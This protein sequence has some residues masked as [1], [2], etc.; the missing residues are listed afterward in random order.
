MKQK[1][2]TLLML[3]LL[4]SP[5]SRGENQPV[6]MPD[7][8]Y[9]SPEALAFQRYGEYEVGEYTGNAQISVPLYTLKYKDI[10]IP[11]SLT[12]QGGGIRVDE[13][14][15]WVGL[16]WNLVVGGCIN[17]IPAG[18][19]DNAYARHAP[20]GDYY[21]FLNQNPAPYF[22]TPENAHSSPNLQQDLR[23]GLGERDFYSVTVLGKTFLFFMNPYTDEPVILG[24]NDQQFKIETFNL[25]WLVTD[26]DGTVFYFE[27]LET[28]RYGEGK[29]Y[30]SAWYLTKIVSSKGAVMIFNYTPAKNIYFL[31]KVCQM[32]DYV[33]EA[34][35]VFGDYSGSYPTSGFRS[36]AVQDTY[37][38]EKGY[39]SSIVTDDC[40]VTFSVGSREDISGSACRLNEINV[41]SVLTHQT[42][43]H[44]SFNYSYFSGENVGGDY[45]WNPLATYTVSD[46]K[47]KR[48]KLI[49]VEDGVTESERLKYGFEYNETKKLPYKTSCAT[50]FW[51]FYNGKEN[52]SPINNFSGT[53]NTFIPTPSSF[54]LGTDQYT[55]LPDG[56]KA[57]AVANRFSDSQYITAGSLRRIIYPTKGYTDFIF[58]PH[59]FLS[60]LS[61]PDAGMEEDNL[62]FIVTDIN[63]TGT[64]GGPEISKL[65]TLPYACEGV[66]EV[67]FNGKQGIPLRQFSAYGAC[68]TLQDV[69]PPSRVSYKVVPLLQTGSLDTETNCTILLPVSLPAGK[70]VMISNLPSQFGDNPGMSVSG[71]LMLR[72]KEAMDHS[73]G[74]GLRIKAIENY[75]NNGILLK[76]TEYEYTKQD[77]TTSGLLLYP[78]DPTEWL[79]IYDGP[80]DKV[81]VTRFKALRL[82]S[83]CGGVPTFTHSVSKGTVGYSRIVKKTSCDQTKSGIMIS[84]YENSAAFNAVSRLYLFT[85]VSNGNL[86]S[87]IWMTSMGD[88]IR[89]T[90]NTYSSKKRCDY[91]C[92]ATIGKDYFPS[93]IRPLIP[94]GIE[95]WMWN[96]PHYF[97]QAYSYFSEWQVLTRSITIDYVDGKPGVKIMHDYEYNSVNHLLTRDRVSSSL[98][99]KK[100]TTEYSYPLSFSDE[101]VYSEMTNKHIWSPIVEQSLYVSEGMMDK[102]LQRKTNM[103]TFM[104]NPYGL[105]FLPYIELY[106]PSGGTL[107]ERIYYNYD[108]SGNIRSVVKDGQS[109]TVYLW[110]YNSMY[111][112]VKIDGATYADV[113]EWLGS[114][115]I[116]DLSNTTTVEAMLNV[117]RERLLGKDVLVTTCT[118]TPLV[119][120]SSKT[121]PYGEKTTYEYDSFGRLSR[122]K[123]HYGKIVEQ[124]D[125]KYK[126]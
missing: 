107:E 38:T 29:G 93:G 113:E 86:K 44:I 12:Y 47:I 90:E 124:H 49:S 79:D 50:D 52:R 55:S 7:F 120:M 63:Y 17:Y 15:S 78:A 16:G 77:G 110:G 76:K 37:L 45:L 35:Q 83:G 34:I 61:Y 1:I 58:E 20:W 94:Q 105:A 28:S 92:N 111:P 109:K 97:L 10:E 3:C 75:D 115:L 6:Q 54:L 14:A 60:T 70:F 123:D 116:S 72:R 112:V 102:L 5:S 24:N 8:L 48:L 57:M 40:N 25:G 73:I 95:E 19:V 41:E 121:T 66:L 21:D 89:K 39:L 27:E 114:D 26:I 104:K 62:T 43:K 18:T 65:F 32:Y 36:F 125:Y 23:N 106:S 11:L 9:K 74:G 64:N 4:Y 117:I 96:P 56:L 51:G 122:V 30:V 85:D 53:K 22:G 81:G 88:T 119:G 67:K 99:E 31:P 126:P 82:S 46:S 42:V 13:E 2:M 71:R 103:Y 33:T 91:K 84:C 87:R 68:V 59:Q 98:C 101:N 118:Y 100:Y 108:Y 69:I 80:G